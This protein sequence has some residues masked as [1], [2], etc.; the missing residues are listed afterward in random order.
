MPTIFEFSKVVV[1]HRFEFTSKNFVEA[2][3]QSFKG[4]SML[5]SVFHG[6]GQ[7]K[8]VYGDSILC[9]S[10]TTAPAVSINGAGFSIAFYLLN[11]NHA[12]SLF[13]ILESHIF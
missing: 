10:Y 2:K 4:L 11:Y 7:T 8:S 3:F 13:E 6:I 1:V 5:Y 9:L 12:V